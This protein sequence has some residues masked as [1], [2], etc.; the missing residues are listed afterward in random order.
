MTDPDD[1]NTSVSTSLTRRGWLT[2]IGSIATA[3]AMGIHGSSHRGTATRYETITVASDEHK[4][5]HVSDGETFA[6]TLIDITA[7]GASTTVR[8][9][10]AD[11]TIKNIGVKGKQSPNGGD[12][13]VDLCEV[14]VPADGS[15]TLENCY[16]GDGSERG[17]MAAVDVTH[18]HAGTLTISNLHAAMWAHGGVN[19]NTCGW[20]RNQNWPKDPGKGTVHIDASFF[21]NCNVAAVLLPS[22]GSS[23]T[24]STIIVDEHAP[25]RVFPGGGE[26]KDMNGV[27]VRADGFARDE[28]KNTDILVTD[29]LSR[30]SP[31]AVT[32]G[33]SREHGPPPYG[34]DVTL[35]ECQLQ[36]KWKNYRELGDGAI[37]TEGLGEEPVLAPPEGVPMNAEKAAS[38]VG[39]RPETI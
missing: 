24:G 6:N 33:E 16:F 26:G 4:N 34:G 5:I 13:D 7:A 27:W 9:S 10:G 25:A 1:E 19:A 28:L 3:T 17:Q 38:G 35:V 21:E 31:A 39:P 30:R 15:A 8:A 12:D 29:E 14:T 11:W 2:S 23:L 37:T 36:R 18:D 32:A 20:S 22:T